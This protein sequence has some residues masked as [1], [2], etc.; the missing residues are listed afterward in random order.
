ML[1]NLSPISHKFSCTIC[2]IKT[3]NKKDF[4]KHLL[5]SKHKNNPKIE[6]SLTESP[7]NSSIHN[8]CSLCNKSYKSR[9]GLWYH[10]KKCG[11]VDSKKESE[12][13]EIDS[14]IIIELLKQNQEFKELLL[15][16][17]STMKS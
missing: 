1:T 8:T 6:H 10:H 3:N 9:V 12:T 5:T 4:N 15:A 7:D 16:L 17:T 14:N 2:N 13:H 11:V